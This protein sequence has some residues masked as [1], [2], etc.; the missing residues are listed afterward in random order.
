MLAFFKHQDTYRKD[1]LG[2]LVS[3]LVLQVLGLKK[4]ISKVIISQKIGKSCLK[5]VLPH[6]TQCDHLFETIK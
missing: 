6:M 4:K 2:A 1:L 3:V 5:A